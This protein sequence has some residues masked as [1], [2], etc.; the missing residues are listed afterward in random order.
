[1]HGGVAHRADGRFHTFLRNGTQERD[2]DVVVLGGNETAAHTLGAQTLGDER[3]NV[4]RRTVGGNTDEQT[5]CMGMRAGSG[6][7]AGRRFDADH[8]VVTE[9]LVFLGDLDPEAVGPGIALATHYEP[10]P[11]ADFKSLMASLPFGPGGSTFVDV[12]SGMG[13]VVM[14]ASQLP[15]KQVIGVEISPALN[16]IARDNL[17]AFNVADQRCRDVRLVRGDALSYRF[18]RGNLVAYLYNPLRADGVARV[19]ER[20][21]SS[22]GPAR[23]VA[24]VYHTPVERAAVDAT[25][26]FELV[27]DLGFGVVYR[28]SRPAARISN[29]DSRDRC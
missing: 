10:T 18:P 26:A 16:A 29:A 28:L 20:L 13:R 1:V 5:D 4:T 7:R 27:A 15:F 19:V 23:E 6:R 24:L 12:G 21:V 17:A 3:D 9:A 8:G 2:G 22:R 25:H 11:V 14:L